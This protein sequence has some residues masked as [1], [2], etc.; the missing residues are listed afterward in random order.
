MMHTSMH[1]HAHVLSAG[2]T[3]QGR[4]IY[5]GN[6]WFKVWTLFDRLAFAA[7]LLQSIVAAWIC[8]LC[9]CR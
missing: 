8:V 4:R 1:R 3:A 5:I 9:C 7:E 6:V 2:F